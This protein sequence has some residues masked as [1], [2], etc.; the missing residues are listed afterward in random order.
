MARFYRVEILTDLFDQTILE[1]T[2]GRIGS[3][4]QRRMVAYS[5]TRSA[6]EAATKI[7]HA[8]E[9]RGYCKSA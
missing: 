3:R 2:W 8:K 6:E 5:S 4:G 9:R 1:Q 7:I